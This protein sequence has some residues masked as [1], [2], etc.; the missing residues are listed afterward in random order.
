MIR[1]NVV[2]DRDTTM[3][4]F[5]NGLNHEVVNVVE[6]QHYIELEDMMY[7][8]MKLERHIKRKGGGA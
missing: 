6:L 8:V 3:T 2:E 7:M 1:A 4:R 5:L